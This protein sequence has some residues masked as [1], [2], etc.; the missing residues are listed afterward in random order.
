MKA[1]S[2]NTQIYS[3]M[4]SASTFLPKNHSKC[5]VEDKK[6]VDLEKVVER[7]K[8]GKERKEKGKVVER[9]PAIFLP[10]S[11]NKPPMESINL[12]RIQ[13]VDSVDFG[14]DHDDNDSLSGGS[15]SEDEGSVT[16][17]ACL[18]DIET[19]SVNDSKN[20]GRPM[21]SLLNDLVQKCYNTQR[22]EKHIFRC[23][24]GCGKTFSN[25]NG[26]RIIRHATGCHY[27]PPEP[28]KRAKAEAASKAPSRQLN[29]DDPE[30]TKTVSETN[31]VEGKGK[32]GPGCVVVMKKR[33]LEE[34]EVG[35]L[36]IKSK[37]Q[38][39]ASSS[40]F[41]EKAK[42]LGRKD[43]HQKLN[44]A[45][46]K[47]F[48]CSGIPTYISDLDV[49][50]DLQTQH[51]VQLL[52]QSWRRFKSLAKQKA[53]SKFRLHT[54][55]PRKTLQFHVMEERQMEELLFLQYMCRLKTERFI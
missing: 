41:F 7:E 30:S 17:L 14:L 10:K 9:T 45:V 23:K 38:K 6:K 20:G 22:P 34:V 39:T 54:F 27:L 48:C 13:G 4:A 50:K 35:G 46:V 33:K 19:K 25:R 26:A 15:D 29:I 21:H 18:I 43:Q 8:G 44:L 36:T 11:A 3:S 51:T 5:D 49:W 28:R 42:A 53:S 37:V 24:G 16:N 32:D 31:D 1:S 2:S 52:A 40:P 47:L 12:K 55:E